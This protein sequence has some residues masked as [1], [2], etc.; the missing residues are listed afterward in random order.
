VSLADIFRRT[1][2]Q[3]DLSEDEPEPA[4]KSPTLRSSAPKSPQTPES[5]ASHGPDQPAHANGEEESINDYMSRLMARVRGEASDNAP[6]YRPQSPRPR[7][8]APPETPAEPEQGATPPQAAESREL[9]EMTP[10]TA[11]PE[12]NIDLSAMREL[13]NMSAQSAIS[14]HDQRTLSLTTRGKLLVAIVAALTGVTLLVLRQQYNTSS[15]TFHAAMASFAV[16]L[17]WGLQ[18]FRLMGR[19]VL[20]KIHQFDRIRRQGT[21]REQAA[22]VVEADLEVA[23]EAKA[24]AEAEKDLLPANDTAVG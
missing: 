3:I 9:V 24:V 11:A 18:Y 21:H 10:R 6:A 22:S 7:P 17:F 19:L 1:G 4:P 15:V 23:D 13:A 2:T 14:R 12:A 20:E 16:C 5:S 8:A